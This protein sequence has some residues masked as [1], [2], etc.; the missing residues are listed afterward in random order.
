MRTILLLLVLSSCG[1]LRDNECRSKEHM[2]LECRA[3][4]QHRYGPY[5]IEMCDRS[6]QAD[7]CY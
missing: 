5:A 3:T 2:R 1:K 4:N 6:Y 7:R